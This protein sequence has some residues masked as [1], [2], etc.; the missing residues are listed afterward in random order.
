MNNKITLI[1][2]NDFKVQHYETCVTCNENTDV[3]IDLHIDY[4]HN[5]VE[6]VGQLCT[7]CF[8]EVY[9]IDINVQV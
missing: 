7:K 1:A 6:C 3:P 5:Y 9:G 8:N 4:R 2:N